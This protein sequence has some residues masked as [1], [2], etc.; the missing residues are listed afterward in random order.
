M[1]KRHGKWY[2]DFMPKTYILPQEFPLLSEDNVG[3]HAETYIC[4]PAGSSQ[5][6][7]I[8]LSDDIIEIRDRVYL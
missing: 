7:G 2:F 3:R 1:A 8:F 4:K 5:G 6:K